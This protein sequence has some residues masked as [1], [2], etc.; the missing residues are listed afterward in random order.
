MS[1]T[2]A[3][4][5]AEACWAADRVGRAIQNTANLSAADNHYFLASHAPIR[6]IVDERTKDEVTDAQ[7][8]DLVFRSAHRNVQAI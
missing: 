4:V 6:R 2:A 1:S 7:Y 3:E 5:R 8:F